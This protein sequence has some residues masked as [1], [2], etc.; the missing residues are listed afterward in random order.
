[1][2][3][4]GSPNTCEGAGDCTYVAAGSAY[5]ADGSLVEESC[6]ATAA[7]PCALLGDDQTA[8]DDD[9]DCEYIPCTAPLTDLCASSPC[10]NGGTC[11]EYRD[12]FECVCAIVSTRAICSC[13]RF[14]D[15]SL[16]LSCCS[17]PHPPSLLSSPCPHPSVPVLTLR[18]AIFPHLSPPVFHLSVNQPA[19]RPTTW[20]H[21]PGHTA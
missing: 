15:P 17:C 9:G 18:T 20:T 5:N 19:V 21:R 8:C 4:P 3:L 6:T 13:V 12:S 16:G 11:T 14:V 2:T 10:E 1:V 7:A